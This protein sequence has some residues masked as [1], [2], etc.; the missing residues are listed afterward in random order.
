M[1][2]RIGLFSAWARA[3]AS[4]PQGYQSTGLWACWRRYGLVSW[5]SRLVWREGSAEVVIRGLRE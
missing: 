4:S 2:S 1:L 3:S 5:I